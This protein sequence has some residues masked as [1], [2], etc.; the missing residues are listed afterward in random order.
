MMPRLLILVA[1]IG[2]TACNSEPTHDVQFYLDNK[3]DRTAK[4][5]ECGNNPG[6]KSFAPNCKNAI[7]AE[8]QALAKG[9]EMP[10]IR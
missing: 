7:A 4:I 10:V 5:A 3:G 2:I 1:A 8:Q 9:T 6:E